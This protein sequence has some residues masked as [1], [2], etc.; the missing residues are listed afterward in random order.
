KIAF[1]KLEEG[2]RSALLNAYELKRKKFTDQNGI[3]N[4]LNSSRAA[5]NLAQQ[6]LEEAE[7]KAANSKV[8]ESESI[9]VAQSLLDK[10]VVDIETE[11]IQFV[12]ALKIKGEALAVVSRDLVEFSQKTHSRVNAQRLSQDYKI[13]T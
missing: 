4:Q 9:L 6:N 2:K 5:L 13:I 10:F 12:E 8:G 3:E 1:L 11:H 7:S